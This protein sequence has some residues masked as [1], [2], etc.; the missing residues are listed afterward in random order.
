MTIR[1]RVEFAAYTR[2]ISL[3]Y[4][5]YPRMYADLWDWQHQYMR[6]TRV[7]VHTAVSTALRAAMLCTRTDRV[8]RI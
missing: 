2:V 5:A 1:D 3:A 4:E 7:A 8:R 6:R